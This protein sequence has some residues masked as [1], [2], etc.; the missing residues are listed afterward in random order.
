MVSGY[1]QWAWQ[2]GMIDRQVFVPSIKIPAKPTPWIELKDRW[3]IWELVD[4][5]HK[6][7]LM[8]SIEMGFRIGE[9]V[10]LQWD[11]IDLD[12]SLIRIMRSLSDRTII[13]MRKGGDE[14]WAPL[15][16]PYNQTATAMLREKRKH[17]KSHWVFPGPKGKHLWSQRVSMAFKEAAREYGLPQPGTFASV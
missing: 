7:P 10:A 16:M 15:N 3:G 4:D 2:E 9:I 17:R 8:L 6:P 1:L 11:C 5:L 14:L 12:K 13:E